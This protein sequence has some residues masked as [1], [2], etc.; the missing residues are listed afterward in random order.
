MQFFD[1]LPK[2]ELGKVK[3]E[4]LR[5]AVL[6]RRSDIAETE[7]IRRLRLALPAERGP[8]LREEIIQ[9]ILRIVDRDPTASSPID[10]DDR[11]TFGQL[12]L[13]SLTSVEL[14]NALSFA[15]GRPL[16]PTVTFDHPTVDDLCDE[17]LKELFPPT[18]VRDIPKP[19]HRSTDR[20]PVAIV[21]IGCR[22]P[23]HDRTIADPE[24]FWRSLKT[25]VD[26]ARVVPRE[27]WN[28]E[29]FYDP[30]RGTPGKTYTRHGSF[31]DDVDRFDAEFFGITP[32]EAKG[33]DPQHRLLL[34]VTWQAL[35]HA[36]HNPL[37]LSD[38]PT[39][40]FFGITGSTYPSANFSRCHA[41]HGPGTCVPVPERARAVDC[42]GHRLLV[43]SGRRS[44][45]GSELAKWG[46][47]GR[48]CRWRQ[49]HDVG[50]TFC[51]SVG[52]PGSGGGW[53]LQSV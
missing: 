20:E 25:G 45:R 37:G 32:S 50:A 29:Q 14:A 3:T 28:V 49:C 4:E 16:S 19:R 33:L 52:H 48:A 13:E 18:H 6:R 44:P 30:I 17:L 22:L 53:S 51:V 42:R 41:V 9:Q 27:R 24:A 43:I 23:G 34:E 35:E 46:M 8:L 26:S 11:A 2:T 12:G 38:R 21:G 10:I 1:A 7:V 15:L 39:G 5:Q 31:V 36:G 47:R 40:V